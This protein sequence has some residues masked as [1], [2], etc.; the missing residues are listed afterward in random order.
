MLYKIG[1]REEYILFSGNN[2]DKTINSV[3]RIFGRS[4][5]FVNHVLYDGLGFVCMLNIRKKG[6]GSKTLKTT[7]HTYSPKMCEEKGAYN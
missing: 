7:C 2:C 5:A 6:Q 3:F 4:V 1:I